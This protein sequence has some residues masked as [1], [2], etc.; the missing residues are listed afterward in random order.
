MSQLE[1]VTCE[2]YDRLDSQLA[3][4]DA[5]TGWTALKLVEWLDNNLPFPYAS[6][7]QKVAWINRAITWWS[8]NEPR[9]HAGRAGIPQVPVPGRR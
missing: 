6:R 7:E 2:I 5:E 3:L 8:K 4:L 9:V 1:K